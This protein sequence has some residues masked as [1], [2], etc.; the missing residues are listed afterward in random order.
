MKKINENYFVK[1]TTI[2][3]TDATNLLDKNE[4]ILWKAKPKKLAYVLSKSIKL[5]PIAII[6]L[7]IDLSIILNLFFSDIF[8]EIGF[9]LIFFIGFFALHLM[10][11]WIWIGSMVKA[12]REMQSLEYIITNKRILEIF[13]QNNKY[14]KTQLALKDM[15]ST[16]LKVSSIDKF[17]K[18]GDIYIS[19]KNKKNMVLFDITDYEFINSQIAK[20]CNNSTQVESPFYTN[21]FECEHCGTQFSSEKVRCPSC[22]APTQK[23]V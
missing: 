20:L 16:N 7:L 10:P 3:T 18:V 15:E 22:G 13:G 5:M 6:W 21:S 11:V 9:M 12:S 23:E 14:I 17:L 2:D 4:K 1:D 19:G 8:N